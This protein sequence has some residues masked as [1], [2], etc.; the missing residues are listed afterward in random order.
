MIAWIRAACP[1]PA[2][3]DG[4]E[5]IQLART[6]CE[7]SDWKQWQYI[8]T[9]AAAYARVGNFKEAVNYQKKA[10]ETVGSTD[11]ERAQ[12]HRCLLLYEQQKPYG[13]EKGID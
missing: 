12:M 5:A 13:E 10:I 2:L 4:T 7:V 6:A 9:L 1:I 8:G 11:R 3:H